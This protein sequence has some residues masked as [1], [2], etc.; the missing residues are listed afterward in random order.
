MGKSPNEMPPDSIDEEYNMPRIMQALTANNS[1]ESEL[2]ESR[3][4]LD[5]KAYLI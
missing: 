5:K 3:V 2:E 1:F 4:D